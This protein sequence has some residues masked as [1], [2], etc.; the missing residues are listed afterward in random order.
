MRRTRAIRLA[1]A[2]IAVVFFTA[3]IA[4]RVL[5]APEQFENRRFAALPKPS[6][7]WDAFGQASRYV[8]DRM[9]L[10]AQAVRLNTQVWR[11]VLGTDPR[12]DRD[13]TLVDDQ[14]LPF[15][16]TAAQ[17]PVKTQQPGRRELGLQP[18]A[19]ASTGQ[20]GWLF[21]GTEITDACS[22][23]N[24]HGQLLSRWASLV[25]AARD[26]GP[27]VVMFAVPDKSSV[28]PEHLPED[29][30]SRDCALRAKDRLWGLLAEQG[31]ELG[32]FELR[33]KLVR[34][35]SRLGNQLFE[36]EDTHWTT[37]GALT[38]VA[39]AL[40]KLG[41]GIQIESGEVVKRGP[42]GYDGDLNIASGREAA[43][44]R[45]EYD[46]VRDEDAPRV[47]GRTVL[48]CDSFAYRK[49]HIF[50]PYFEDIRYVSLYDGNEKVVNAISSA[51]HV[52]FEAAEHNLRSYVIGDAAYVLR[53]AARLR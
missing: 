37:L 16:G 42:V 10:R 8:I 22:G 24:Q 52:I 46:I 43:A 48:I 19:T 18:P 31:P 44:Q 17:D 39:A 40:D 26:A 50:R 29:D 2:A 1:F 33:S 38:L 45:I 30:P 4:S 41:E 25:K 21:S 11:D 12:Y 36:R 51:D 13:T 49:M 53:L 7:G 32:V 15:A 3:P 35:K 5:V 23:E 34:L 47:P 20:E 6:Q 27:T 28:Y 9:P 14:A